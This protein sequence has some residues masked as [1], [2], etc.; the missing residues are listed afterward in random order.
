M[1]ENG[2]AHASKE[3]VRVDGVTT[4]IDSLFCGLHPRTTFDSGWNEFPCVQGSED[5]EIV[6]AVR[7]RLELIR[8]SLES[9]SIGL[10]LKLV[11]GHLATTNVSRDLESTRELMSLSVNGKISVK[12]TG[13]GN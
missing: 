6:S 2:T 7:W 11:D 3:R 5:K 1:V 13:R 8:P 9:R 12:G 10:L 4:L